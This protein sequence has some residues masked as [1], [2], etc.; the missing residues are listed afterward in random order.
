MIHACM[1]TYRGQGVNAGC[2]TLLTSIFV[3]GVSPCACVWEVPVEVAGRTL[4]S[5]ELELW[6]VCWEPNSSKLLTAELARSAVPSLPESGGHQ[7]TGWPASLRDSPISVP[8]PGAMPG[9][10]CGHWSSGSTLP[11]PWIFSKR[12]IGRGRVC[13]PIGQSNLKSFKLCVHV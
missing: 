9:F 1:C 2:P 13:C 11:S 7:Q 10:L 3:L 12:D 4:A 8:P 6:A 5:L